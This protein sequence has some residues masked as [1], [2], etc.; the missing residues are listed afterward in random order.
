MYFRIRN[1][2]DISFKK[3]KTQILC[4]ITFFFLENIAV[5]EVTWKNIVEPD[6]PE[7]TIWGIARWIPKATN[8]NSVYVIRIAFPLQ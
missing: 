3:I 7:T 1:V 2:S 5:H 8:P 4:S 6:R